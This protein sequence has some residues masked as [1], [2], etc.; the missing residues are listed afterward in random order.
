VWFDGAAAWEKIP[1]LQ[2]DGP[3]TFL[4]VE[5]YGQI[6]PYAFNPPATQYF[7][8]VLALAPEQMTGKI[9]LN[10]RLTKKARGEV[11]RTL[12]ARAGVADLRTLEAMRSAYRRRR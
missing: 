2:N 7:C 9:K 11:E 12:E 1:T 10:Q 5:A 3:C 4:V 8:V 6:P